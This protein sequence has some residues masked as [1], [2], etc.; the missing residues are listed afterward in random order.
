MWWLQCYDLV[1]SRS[2]RQPFLSVV[3]K[4]DAGSESDHCIDVTALPNGR[5]SFLHH[6]KDIPAKNN[7]NSCTVSIQY[8][9][10]SITSTQ[11]NRKHE[12]IYQKKQLFMQNLQSHDIIENCMKIVMTGQIT[13]VYTV[14]AIY[15]LILLC[16][17][18]KTFLF[19]IQHTFLAQYHSLL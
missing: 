13:T 16:P 11:P 4:H 5:C 3:A 7:K 10:S 12:T 8:Y 19:I 6:P 2:N 1:K 17:V 18:S 14:S 9:V 15:C